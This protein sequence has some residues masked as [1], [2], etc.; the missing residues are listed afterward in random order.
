MNKQYLDRNSLGLYRSLVSSH[1]IFN[2]LT[3]IQNFI[4]G[5]ETREALTNLSRFAKYLRKL[6]SSTKEIY[7]DLFH[8]KELV[9]LYL[10][11]EKLRF[12]EQLDYRLHL[13][14][15]VFSESHKV[16]SLVLLPA[17]E[18]LLLTGTK[19]KLDR[20][21]LDLYFTENK[22]GNLVFKA[23]LKGKTM[24]LQR[25]NMNEEQAVRTEL[26]EERLVLLEKFEDMQ[27]EHEWQYNDND[28]I[29]KLITKV[30]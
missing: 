9:E 22:N 18:K 8:E 19:S 28:T 24:P 16:P 6:S 30:K 12:G 1:A 4:T 20:N 21:S 7:N 25:E 23:V 27:M 15:D 13:D 11:M 3:A 14:A 26:T 2:S 17:I 10:S 29:F 5:E